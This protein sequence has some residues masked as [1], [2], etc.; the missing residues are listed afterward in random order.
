[1]RGLGW[2]DTYDLS[3]YIYKHRCAHLRLDTLVKRRF[4]ACIM[5]IFNIMSGKMNSQNLLSAFDLNTPRY[6]TRCSEFLR[7]GFHRTNY[8]FHGPMSAAMREFNAVI[9]LF[10][11]ILTR[12]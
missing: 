9:G 4:I 1:M 10:E 3:P 6:R 2:T 7:I 11:F 5:F 12:N 8:G